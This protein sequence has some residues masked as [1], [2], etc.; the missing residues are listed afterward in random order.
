MQLLSRNFA[1]Q[2]SVNWYAAQLQL[3]PK[4]L[5]QLIKNVS[6]RTVGQ[7]VSVLVVMEIKSLL[8]NTDLSIKEISSGMNF[9]SQ[10]L[11]GRYFKNYTGL[12][13]LDYRR[14]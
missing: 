3:T 8:R 11:M 4:S 1:E 9:P 7:W 14:H 6:G 12:S 5:S 13:P 10:S 2:R